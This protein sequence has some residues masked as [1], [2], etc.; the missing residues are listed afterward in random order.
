MC[1]RDRVEFSEPLD[2]KTVQVGTSFEFVEVDGGGGETPVPGSIVV[3][4]QHISFDPQQVE[5]T[6]GMTYRLRLTGAI[7]DLNGEALNPVT[8]E[9]VPVDSNSCGCVITQRFNTTNAFG[10]SGF[11]TTS[12]LTGRPLNAIDLYSPLIGSNE[13]NLRDTT[14]EARL[15]DPSAFGG[16]IPFVIRK[17][18][19]LDITGLDLALG[20]EVPANL[21]TGDITASFITDVTGYMDRNPYLSLIHI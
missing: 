4:K 19:Y 9:L 6:A 17:G 14:L 21:Q 20:G 5:L 16:L 13:I 2:E 8:Y 10:E 7:T 15:A 3:R 12:R 18:A 1:I 11:P